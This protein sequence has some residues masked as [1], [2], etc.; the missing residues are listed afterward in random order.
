MQNR[1]SWRLHFLFFC[2]MFFR[3]S[4]NISYGQIPVIPT[5]Q[6][7]TMP[8]APAYTPRTN[9][10]PNVPNYPVQNQKNQLDMYEQDRRMIERRDAEVKKTLNQYS[11]G[12]NGIQYNIPSKADRQTAE[13]YLK[14][15]KLLNSMLNGT[16]PISLKDAVFIVDNT[17]TR[18]KLDYSKYNKAIENLVTI[19]KLA[20]KQDGY[21]WNDPIT[22]NTMLFRVMADTLKIKIPNKEK[23]ITSYPMRYN[24]A[25]Y[26]GANDWMS[27]SVSKLLATQ[28]GQ[29]H[30]MP[31]LYLILCEAT[32]TEASLAYSPRHSYAKFKD[33]TGKWYNLELTNGY[34]M[35]DALIIGSGF[36]TADALKSKIYMEPQNRKEVIA[37]CL[38]DLASNYVHD[39]GYDGFALQCA[40]SALKYAP[41]SL[42]SMSMKA[43]CMTDQFEY[44]ANQVGRPHPDTLKIHY[45]KIYKIYEERN[46][47]YRWLDE[48]GYR[49]MP[50]EAYN[51][52]LD[53]IGREKEK[54]EKQD[55]TRFLIQSTK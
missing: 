47:T 12:R 14:A 28:K 50:E 13:S 38:N 46:K 5:I 2:F 51:K 17:F 26:N 8:T 41:N 7:A 23:P 15:A 35:S 9:N 30:S 19:A 45:P 33:Q 42:R 11:V 18:G 29:C 53:F 32:N 48:C 43:N 4:C 55:K 36:I 25:D 37:E 22:R 44:V 10:S 54:Q 40:D 39:F 21:H 6:P 27:M 24:Y 31:L 1:I 49:E 16:I 20:T 52:W 34:V 3:L